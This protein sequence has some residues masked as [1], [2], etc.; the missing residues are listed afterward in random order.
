[1]FCGFIKVKENETFIKLY[2]FIK[3]IILWKQKN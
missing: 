1:M 2:I 3:D